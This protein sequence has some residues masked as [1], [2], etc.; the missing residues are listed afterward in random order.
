MSKYLSFPDVAFKDRGLLLAALAD[1][2]YP[3]VEEGEAFSLF[4]YQSDRRPETA[5]IVVRRHHSGSASKHV[6]GVAGPTC[7]DI[8]KL[9]KELLGEPGQEQNTVEYYQRIQVRPQVRPRVGR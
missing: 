3:Q 9:A 6:K 7:Y 2:G 4:G 5:E 8:V 1:L